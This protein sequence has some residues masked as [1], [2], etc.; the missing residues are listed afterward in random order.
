ML[1][2]KKVK[3]RKQ[4]RTDQIRGKAHRGCN[5]AFGEYGMKAIVAG[6]ITSRQIEAAR[7]A[8]ARHMNRGGDIYIRVFPDVV[9]TIGTGVS[10]TKMGGGKGGPDHYVAKIRAGMII[11]E[12]GGVDEKVA[13]EALRLGQH[14]ISLSTKFVIKHHS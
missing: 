12:V 13:K 5:V 10:G 4:F 6:F 14:K 7:R 1:A 3:Y 11:F 9:R 2:P 8:M